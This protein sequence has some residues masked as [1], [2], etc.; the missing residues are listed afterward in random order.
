M[1]W[2]GDAVVAELRVPMRGQCASVGWSRATT[3]GRGA[4][5]GDACNLANGRIQGGNRGRVVGTLELYIF[6]IIVATGVVVPSDACSLFGVVVLAPLAE[7]RI[8]LL[9]VF[10]VVAFPQALTRVAHPL[11]VPSQAHL[12]PIHLQSGELG[13]LS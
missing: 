10:H 13:N 5:G 9:R 11:S 4:K 6:T 7:R 2:L 8:F 12:L 1:R 3:W